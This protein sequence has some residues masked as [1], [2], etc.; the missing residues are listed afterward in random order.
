MIAHHGGLTFMILMAAQLRFQ[1]DEIIIGNR[2]SISGITF[3]SIGA[4]IVDYAS[5]VVLC[6]AQ[7]FVPMSSHSEARGDADGLRKILIAGNRACAFVILPIAATLIVL[8][9]SGIEVWMGAKYV[10]LSYPV[11]VVMI[12]PFTL[13]LMQGA[14]T[15]MLM[16]T[17]QH[18]TFGVVALLEGIANVILS[19]V[20][21][22]PLGIFGDA[23]G[24]AIPLTCT[25][26][27]FLPRHACRRF[28]IGL[29]TF[30]RES[31]TLPVL[32]SV[33]FVVTLLLEHRWFVP[34][35][36]LELILQCSIAWGIYGLCF[37][38]IY[39]RKQAFHINWAG[40]VE[41]NQLAAA[42]K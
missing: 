6:I 16:G 3:F 29:L 20:L 27:V 4:R 1:T 5:N 40:A 41:V 15:R 38:R 35:H 22:R 34:H 26:L 2:L 12:I 23:L 7:L 24:T 42:K 36:A 19:L 39:K 32:I 21:I 14:S 30:L 8:G 37:L 28:G 18:G 33:P 31:Y 9:R 11:L 13:M 10:P 25:V 17:S